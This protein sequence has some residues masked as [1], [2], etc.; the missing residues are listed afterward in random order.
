VWVIVVVQLP[1]TNRGNTEPEKLIAQEPDLGS[2]VAK[3]LA[4]PW[5]NRILAELLLRPMSPKEFTHEVGGPSLPTIAR[6]FR[7]LKRWG[8]LEVAEER[9]GGNRRG[10]VEKVYRA[11]Q[12]INFD[13]PAW[14]QLPRYL[15]S[16]CSHSMMEGLIARITEA[17][18]AGTF[19]A[20]KDRHLS[21]KTVRLDREAWSTHSKHLDV[22]LADLEELEVEAA[23]RD[24]SEKDALLATVGLLAFRSP[25]HQDTPLEHRTPPQV[26]DEQPHFLMSASTAKALANPWRNR[27]LAELHARSMSPKQFLDEVGGPDLPTVARYF[28]QLRKWG[29]LEVVEELTGGARRGSVEKMYRAIRRVRFSSP[30]WEQLPLEVRQNCSVS[31]LDGL[32]ERLNDAIAADTLDAEIDRFLC[33]KTVRFDRQA[34]KRFGEILDDTLDLVQVLE[35]TSAQRIAN[36]GTEAVPATVGLLAFRSPERQ[37]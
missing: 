9:R 10:A 4:N 13:T 29:Y 18:K 22:V 15:R 32:M 20:E 27:I 2:R 11:I 24:L 34:W 21:W 19:D 6:Y 16:E 33:W 8:F 5:R 17:V 25:D 12:R 30:T 35:H 1:L 28:R 31:M 7:E 37:S 14:E 26:G 36:L 23:A 3:P